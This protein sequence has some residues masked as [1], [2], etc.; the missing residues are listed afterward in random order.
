MTL[1]WVEA[2]EQT[3]VLMSRDATPVAL[4]TVDA[5]AEGINQI[6]WI[7]STTPSLLSKATLEGEAR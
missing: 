6:M 7:M 5:S 3:A 4:A 2:N 1:A